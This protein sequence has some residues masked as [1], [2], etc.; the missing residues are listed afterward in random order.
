[1]AVL[2]GIAA[3]GTAAIALAARPRR[4][5]ALGPLRASEGLAPRPLADVVPADPERPRRK[6]V[7]AKPRGKHWVQMCMEYPGGPGPT[8]TTSLRA[9]EILRKET[10]L[11]RADRESFYAMY[12]DVRQQLLGIEEI[13][14]GDITGVNVHPREAFR[15]AVLAGASA[16]IFA[17][18]HPSE[19]TTPSEDDLM[20]TRRLFRVGQTMGIP[21]LDHLV[22]ARPGA[23]NRGCFSIAE[24]RPSLF[25]TRDED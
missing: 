20:L 9:C 12:M 10:G 17:H 2:S 23:K 21:V 24:N 3:V 4:G 13:A 16:I 18:N 15:G 19:D 1:M 8:A 7:C 22:V 11:D 6:V 14:R 25:S 5:R